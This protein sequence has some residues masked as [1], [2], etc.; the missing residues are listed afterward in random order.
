[1][2][3]TLCINGANCRQSKLDPVSWVSL[4]AALG[5]SSSH[6]RI[7]NEDENE[8]DSGVKREFTKI[9]EG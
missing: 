7:G 2:K 6:D 9:S 3:L 8:E 5:M 1:M 4:R